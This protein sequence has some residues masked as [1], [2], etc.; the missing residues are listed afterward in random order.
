MVR[1]PSRGLFEITCGLAGGPPAPVEDPCTP[2]LSR[3]SHAGF[4]FASNRGAEAAQ[5]APLVRVRTRTDGLASPKILALPSAITWRDKEQAV[6]KVA[7]RSYRSDERRGTR[8][9]RPGRCATGSATARV[10]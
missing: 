2:A 6:A 7:V 1:E 10:P 3:D 4:S 8:R 5:D 9:T